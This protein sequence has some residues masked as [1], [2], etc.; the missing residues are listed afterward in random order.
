LH[1]RW[2]VLAAGTLAQASYTAITLGVAVLAPVLR[3][4]Y[5]LSLTEIGV[6]LAAPNAGSI[7]TLYAWG[8]ATDRVGERLVIGLGLGAA[9]LFVTAAAFAPTFSTLTLCLFGAG[10]VG[11]S[12]NSA[13]GRAVL[14]WFE[15]HQR[16][17]ALGIR[18]T[19]VPIGG[20]WAAFF[21]PALVTGDDP[22]PAMLA[23]AGGLLAG[24]LAGLFVVREGP[25]PVEPEPAR[26]EVPLRDRAMWL[27][28]L[29]SGCV[30]APQVCVVASSSSSCT[31]TAA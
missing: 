25:E 15:A 12:V 9:T 14:H 20:A 31:A 27:L 18:Q 6:V 24:T 29:G 7:F 10:A 30:I 21:L 1:Y 19:A 2:A 13:S 23:L 3:E 28:S 17:L 11:A 16:G 22:R 5:H 26:I 8:V 4:H